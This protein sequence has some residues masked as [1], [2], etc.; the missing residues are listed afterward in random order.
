MAAKAKLKPKASTKAKAMAKAAAVAAADVI[1]GVHD[2]AMHAV[3]DVAAHATATA[4]GVEPPAAA[5]PQEPPSKKIK[6]DIM[7]HSGALKG[8]GT[9][10]HD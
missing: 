4:L 6:L 7:L 9:F 10:R 5:E 3:A 1:D 2:A 8:V